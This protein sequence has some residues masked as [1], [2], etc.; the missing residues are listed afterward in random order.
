[1]TRELRRLSS[2][3]ILRARIASSMRWRSIGCSAENMKK[4]QN[5]SLKDMASS[6]VVRRLIAIPAE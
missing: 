5:R 3:A 1:M 2:C 4:S 6:Y